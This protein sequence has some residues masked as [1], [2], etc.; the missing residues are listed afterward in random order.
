M[1]Y[2]FRTAALE[3]A[4]GGSGQSFL[5]RVLEILDHYPK[6]VCDVLMNSLS[7]HDVERALTHL[8]GQ[9]ANGRDRAWQAEHMA[10]DAEAYRRGARLL[11]LAALLQYTLPGFP[12]LYYGDEAGMYGY[13]DPFNRGC[14]PWGNEDG[15]LVAF[16]R[17]LGQFRHSQTPLKEGG[18]VPLAADD[19]YV[20]Y[21]R[22][23]G[24]SALLVA[25][26]SGEGERTVA[27]PAGFVPTEA[28]LV[29]GS[30]NRETA[31][32]GPRSGLLLPGRL[33]GPLPRGIWEEE[34]SGH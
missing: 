11:R 8:A 4:A 7:T 9:P 24:Q 29:V 16:F 10:L 17:A 2:P 30:W 28:G 31:T 13:R 1:N 18:F 5:L 32:L 33:S 25:V 14:Y 15:E 27:L 3:L 26:N 23:E 12:C 6:C 34:N 19:G 22:A 20:C 21:L